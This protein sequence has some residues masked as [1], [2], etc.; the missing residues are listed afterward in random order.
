MNVEGM[1]PNLECTILLHIEI[2][3]QLSIT[4]SQDV[5]KLAYIDLF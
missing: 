1:D 2:E 5:N 3:S 4:I